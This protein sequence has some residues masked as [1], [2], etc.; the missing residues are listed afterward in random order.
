MVNLKNDVYKSKIFHEN[1][2]ETHEQDVLS[3]VQSLKT[4]L[5]QHNEFKRNFV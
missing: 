5:Q 2:L 4:H 3:L 1:G